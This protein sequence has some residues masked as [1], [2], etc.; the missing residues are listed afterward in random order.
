MKPALSRLP[1]S[2]GPAAVI[3]IRVAAGTI[4]VSE[5]VQT[6]LFPDALGAGRFAKIGLP[7]PSATA[8]FVG[9]VEI[10]AGVLLL[11]GLLTRIAAAALVLDMCVALLANASP[12]PTA[13]GPARA[14]LPS[15]H[16]PVSAGG[17]RGPR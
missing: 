8:S 10:I 1:R 14:A 17:V 12:P 3:L 11:I 9:G 2:D 15:H 5:G 13:R 4:F 6:F 7:F 16:R